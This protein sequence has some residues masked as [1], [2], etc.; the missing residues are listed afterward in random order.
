MFN[1]FMNNFICAD[2]AFDYAG[3]LPDEAVCGKEKCLGYM[4]NKKSRGGTHRRQLKNLSHY[5]IEDNII[6]E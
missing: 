1:D 5:N 2:R 4:Y 6:I 3:F